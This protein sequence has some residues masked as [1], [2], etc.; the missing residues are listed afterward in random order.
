[1]TNLYHENPIEL[2]VRQILAE[3][4]DAAGWSDFRLT[5]ETKLLDLGI[6][7]S[8]DLI[9]MILEVENY[10]ECEFDPVEI[11]LESGLTLSGFVKSF[12]TKGDACD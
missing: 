9:E 11:D 1:M 5:D 7:D 6:I 3:R 4:L 12:I 8:E 10:F 2:K